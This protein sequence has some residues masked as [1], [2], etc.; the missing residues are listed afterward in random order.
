MLDSLLHY[1]KKINAA[2]IV[3]DLG[4]KQPFVLAT[5]HRQEN[6]NNPKRYAAILGGL[7]KIAEDITVVLPAHPRLQPLLN[8]QHFKAFKIITPQP[9]LNMLALLQQCNLVLTDSGGLQKE[10]FYSQ[11]YCITLREE[12]E[13]T[14][15]LNLDVN[16]LVKPNAQEIKATF[17]ALHKRPFAKVLNPYGDGQTAER[18]LSHLGL[19]NA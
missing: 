11:K 6:L 16:K 8:E 18:I 7:E 10:A 4:I 19:T 17:T 2:Q 13:W 15:L 9:Y 5:L 1:Q 12:T 3:H 14:E